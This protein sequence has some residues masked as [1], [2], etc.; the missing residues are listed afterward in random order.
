M[1]LDPEL[2]ITL[3]LCRQCLWRLGRV[4]PLDYLEIDILEKSIEFVYDSK[5]EIKL[6]ALQAVFYMTK[7]LSDDIIIS[8]VKHFLMD[9][10]GSVNVDVVKLICKN[11]Q[12]L[13]PIVILDFLSY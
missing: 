9:I 12:I 8:R 5:L 3:H 10:T 13:F 1:A 4:I 7:D 11:L 6:I 2:S